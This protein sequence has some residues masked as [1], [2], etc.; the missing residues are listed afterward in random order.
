MK[1]TI[2]SPGGKMKL[3]IL[4]YGK[5]P[6]ILWIHG[7]GYVLGMAAMVYGS[8][9]KMLAKHYGGV[10]VSPEYRLAKKAP[11]PAALEDWIEFG[12]YA[13]DGLGAANL[14]PA[15]FRALSGWPGVTFSC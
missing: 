11:Y 15:A 6:G 2:D 1:R 5:G 10:V 14:L 7:G 9:G 4:Q 8:M 13:L 12:W 3:I